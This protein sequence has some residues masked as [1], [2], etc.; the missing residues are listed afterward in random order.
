MGSPVFDLFEYPSHL[1]DL[2]LPC[3]LSFYY[4]SPLG[5]SHFKLFPFIFLKV[6]SSFSLFLFSQG[7]SS[8]L[9]FHSWDRN[10]DCFL[11][12]GLLRFNIWQVVRSTTSY[13]TSLNPKPD[14]V[15]LQKKNRRNASLLALP[16][17]CGHFASSKFLA[18]TKSM[19]EVENAL[20]ELY[21]LSTNQ[22][23]NAYVNPTV[24]VQDLQRV[25]EAEV[26]EDQLG[27][28]SASFSC[29]TTHDQV[30][31][32]LFFFRENSPS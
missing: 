20:A 30:W 21:Q 31:F 23:E 6:Q 29:L 10:F 26:S 19:Q 12:G 32:L 8:L 28:D 11:K 9:I 14:Q 2:G 1:T 5:F 3:T 16:Q 24:L 22:N 18:A 4:I 13:H 25:V 15:R 17:N 7:P 27:K